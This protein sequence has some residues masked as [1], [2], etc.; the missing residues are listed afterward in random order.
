MID[1]EAF[2]M[3][4]DT[5]LHRILQY[6][7]QYAPDNVYGGFHGSIGNDNLSNATAEKGLVLHARILWSFSAAYQFSG[8]AGYLPVAEKAHH[9]LRNHFTDHEYGGAYWSLDAQGK[10]LNQRKQVYGLAFYLYALSEYYLAAG[11]NAVLDEAIA[12]FRLIEEKSFDAVHKGYLEAFDRHWQPM[13]DL[14]LSDKDANEKKTM[15]TH[16]HIIEAYASLYRI[17]PDD[18]LRTQITGLLQLFDQHF[19]SNNTGHLLLFFDEHWNHQPNVISYGHDIE[20]AWL[21]QRCAEV[22]K[23]EYWVAAMKKHALNITPAAAEGLDADGGLWYE[24]NPATKLLIKEKHWWPQA[25]AMPGFFNAWEISGNERWL[26]AAANSWRFI[27]KHIRDNENGEWFW[28]VEKD[29]SI[30][31]GKDK[32]GFWKCPY[33]NSRAC[34][35]MIRRIKS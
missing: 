9:Y 25:E 30:M 21:L 3:E 31:K 17:W 16:L 13:E 4:L 24:Y 14:R 33:H 27:K 26:Y 5:E 7:M 8:Q 1:L 28:G 22:I 19:I 29:Y 10:P 23:D 32:A 12:L 18:F 20:A 15:N 11:T 35:E 6:W 2:S 34:M